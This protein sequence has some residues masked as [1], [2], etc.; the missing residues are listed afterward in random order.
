MGADISRW[1]TIE[2]TSKNSILSR[3]EEGAIVRG[4]V[5]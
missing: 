2:T 4:S 1:L 3:L 5:K